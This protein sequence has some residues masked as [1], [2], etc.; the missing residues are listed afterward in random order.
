[1]RT[2]HPTA[3][4]AP[5]SAKASRG[6]S[7]HSQAVCFPG[8]MDFREQDRSSQAARSKRNQNCC[9]R[10]R[11]KSSLE[12]SSFCISLER[13][14]R[15]PGSSSRGT[16]S[17][18]L[19]GLRKAEPVTWVESS[20]ERAL[21]TA[22]HGW[23]QFNTCTW[24]TLFSLFS[25]IISHSTRFDNLFLLHLLH[26]LT[27]KPTNAFSRDQPTHIAATGFFCLSRCCWAS[28]C[29]K[30][31]TNTRYKNNQKPEK[32]RREAPLLYFTGKKHPVRVN[33]AS[34]NLTHDLSLWW[35]EARIKG[36][37]KEFQPPTF[38]PTVEVMSL[39]L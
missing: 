33:A 14:P 5:W 8:Q 12:T 4:R 22:W 18:F 30:W 37:T 2:T 26:G 11:E 10:R 3:W 39:F 7:E 29:N 17:Y 35:E 27:G 20:K 36:R 15:S 24:K 9:N 1:M 34:L 13:V 21:F 25:N 32:F 16:I 19:G 28:F 23:T 31:F 38:P 6:G